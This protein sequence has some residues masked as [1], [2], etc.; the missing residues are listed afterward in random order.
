VE[1]PA[2]RDPADIALPEGYT[3]TMV[4]EGLTF[5]TGVAVDEQGRPHVV[6]AGYSYGEKT[7]VPRLVRVEPDGRFTVVATG[8]NNGPW[9]GVAFAQGAFFVAEGGQ[10]KGG[11]ILR[12]EPTGA[13][14]AL[15]A[16]L[17]SFGDH[18]TDGPVIGKD[19]YVYFGQGTATN[20]G[21]VG[22][23][24][25]H[26]G[27]LS[28]FP[29]FHDIPCKDVVL[30]GVNY[31][32]VSPLPDRPGEVE[33]GAYSP[34]GTRTSAGQV[35]PGR[36]PCSGAVMRV[37]LAGGPPELVAWGFRNPFG[38]AFA[39]DGRLFVTDNGIDERGLRVA[40]G[41][42]DVLWE[43]TPG[44]WYG[45]PDFAEGKPSASRRFKPPGDEIPRALL[46]S[47]PGQ[48]PSPKAIFGSHSSANGL[49]FSRSR[50]FG[51]VGQAF[52]ALFG[53]MA[54]ETG[55]LLGPVGFKVVRVDTA[56]GVIEDFATNHGKEPGP[57]SKLKSG[58]LE[59]PVAVRFDP[60]GTS[61]YVVDFGI[62]AVTDKGPLP[63][64]RT[65]VLWKITRGGAP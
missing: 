37:P 38:L 65:G 32:S 43:V 12:I 45:W 51:H 6:E 55:K 39:P 40:F 59:R 26:Y 8:T 58:G 10:F 61:L 42:G 22:P 35:I 2:P 23:D 5:P 63:V 46:Q 4:A 57:A 20:A 54:G 27:W 62:L 24:N 9:N 52:V 15:V 28:R 7:A 19:G 50:A 48:P 36:L 47:Y 21:I 44:A 30:A 3:I 18:H 11:R 25:H 29:D 56:T 34:F 60:A 53:D 16:D 33:T 49:D 13:T 41:P 1:A 17:P 14:R 64:E 31:R